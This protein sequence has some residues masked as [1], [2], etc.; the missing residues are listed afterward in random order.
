M[1]QWDVKNGKFQNVAIINLGDK[2]LVHQAELLRLGL[3]PVK[4]Y[5]H[6]NIRLEFS[7]KHDLSVHSPL[8]R[9]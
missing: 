7:V 1:G 5:T 2:Y 4:V 6:P 3:R 8:T 9:T